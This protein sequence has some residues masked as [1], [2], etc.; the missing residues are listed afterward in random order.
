MTALDIWTRFPVIF[1]GFVIKTD[2]YHFLK[3]I[4]IFLIF[5]TDICPAADIQKFAYRYFNKIFWL[6]L[7]WIVNSL[8]SKVD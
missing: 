6:K 1:G 2:R 4:Q 3:P 5:F 7:V 8:I